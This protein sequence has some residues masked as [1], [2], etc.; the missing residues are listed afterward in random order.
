MNKVEV[1]GLPPATLVNVV[2]TFSLCVGLNSNK[3]VMYQR[4]RFPVKVERV[5]LVCVELTA[6]SD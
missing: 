5:S 1:E 2:C 3:L 4:L 6:S